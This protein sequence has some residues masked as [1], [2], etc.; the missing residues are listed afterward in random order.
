MAQ[1]KSVAHAGTAPHGEGADADQTTGPL[2][3]AGCLGLVLFLSL[4]GGAAHADAPS[5]HGAAV[6]H[7]SNTI[8]DEPDEPAHQKDAL[9]GRAEGEP[10]SPSA[11]E[12]PEPETAPTLGA[13]PDS[14]TKPSAAPLVQADLLAPPKPS[15]PKAV[16]PP[17]PKPPEPAQAPVSEGAP[18]APPAPSLAPPVAPDPAPPAPAPSAE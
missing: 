2:F 8:P 6:A 15:A 13:P 5:T 18:S 12:I 10:G 17:A 1:E 16:R 9:S 3:L 14:D 11:E 7:D 4:S